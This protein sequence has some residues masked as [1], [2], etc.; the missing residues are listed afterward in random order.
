MRRLFD[1]IRWTRAGER[2]LAEE[3]R[4]HLDLEADRLVAE[5]GMSR[6]DARAAARRGFGNVLH[7]REDSRAVWGFARLE[8]WA[9]DVRFGLRLLARAPLFA[10][11]TIAS[12]AVGVGASVAGFGVLDNVLMR[13]LPVPAPDRLLLF[14]WMAGQRHEL[15]PQSINGWLD[16][17][18]GGQRVST[19]LS[20]PA[21]THLRDHQEGFSDLVAFAEVSSLLVQ[22][23]GNSET[24]SGQY[25]SGNY[26]RGLAVSMVVGRP[27]APSDDRRDADAV[28]VVSYEAWQR[29]F[30]GSASVVGARV[31]L[32]R[33]PVVIVGV[34]PR[35]FH[36]C[37]QLGSSPEFTVP[38][39]LQPRITPGDG[40]GLD[41]PG[42]WWVQVMGRLTEGTTPE[43][44]VNG[45]AVL[46][47]RHLSTL[48]RPSGEVIDVPR[49][50]WQPGAQGLSEQRRELASPVKAVAG[51]VSLVL[52]VATGNVAGLLLARTTARARE[53]ALRLAVGA[54]RARLVRQVFTESLTLSL[55]GGGAGVVLSAWIGPLL[56][57]AAQPRASAA[58]VVP[59]RLD[60]PIA[61]I[62][63]ALSALV[64]ITL[65]LVT[66]AGTRFDVSMTSREKGNGIGAGRASLQLGRLLVVGQ[67][68]LSLLLLVLAGLFVVT[69]RNVERVQTG[70]DVAGVLSFRIEPGLQGYEGE[71]LKS[72]LATTQERLEALPGVRLA[73]FSRHALF[74]GSSSISTVVL[75]GGAKPAVPGTP[76]IAG[77]P[78]A[79][80]H[81]VGGRYFE[82][83]GIRLLSGRRFADRDGQGG[84]PVAMVNRVFA[85]NFFGDVH[86]VGR[87][88]ASSEKDPF[89][90]IV[91]VVE[92]ARYTELRA[93]APPTIYVPFGSRLRMFQTATFYA[94]TGGDPEA[95]VPAVRRVLASVDAAVPVLDVT[96]LGRQVERATDRERRAAITCSFFA[97]LAVLLAWIGLYGLMAYAVSRRTAEIGVRLAMGATP[98]RLL[99]DVM[100]ES[101][102]IVAA[103]LVLGGGGSLAIGR[104]VE[105]QLFGVAPTDALTLGAGTAL[106]AAV[107][108]TAGFLPA[109]RASRVDPL[110]ALRAE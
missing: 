100:K 70:V 94:R 56:L 32:N 65:G 29:R 38:I 35:G 101:G 88:I 39:A 61:A 10:F 60:L 98:R 59:Y 47:D 42:Y 108:L 76:S 40:D 18:E 66:A 25:V 2:E 6:E 75:P 4:A 46:F 109:R 96:T 53:V 107:A 19:S 110:T 5:E 16:L 79:W 93:A 33:V 15:L 45:A 14:K 7:A 55:L 92:D 105:T 22:S 54:S 63:L 99:A 58:I 9:Q 13:K 50:G 67:I 49:L 68:A 72:L 80:M 8:T 11:V 62:G 51:L 21:Y 52:L 104:L 73:A 82:V 97:A 27:L 90:E 34:M 37:L 26:F 77:R 103:G 74:T 57:A 83:L 41:D 85:Q 20:Y 95:L 36:G 91:G 28:A 30:G 102:G 48:P 69:L 87:M 86:A 3:I 89:M 106:V 78:I 44:A 17:D 23:G 24:S 31:L 43:R 81:A 64:G 12:L 1:W 84:P 71:R